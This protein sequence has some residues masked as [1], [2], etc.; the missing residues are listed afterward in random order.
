MQAFFFSFFLP[1][2]AVAY[3]K[4]S[5]FSF[6]GSLTWPVWHF[7]PIYTLICTS[8]ANVAALTET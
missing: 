6:A 5:N 7:G 8:I 2:L 4:V 3:S 1:S